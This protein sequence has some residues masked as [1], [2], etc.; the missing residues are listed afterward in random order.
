MENMNGYY[1]AVATGRGDFAVIIP[2]AQLVVQTGMN[3]ADA[4]SMASR[5]NPPAVDALAVNGALSLAVAV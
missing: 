5:F 3:Q 2:A 1:K 4:E